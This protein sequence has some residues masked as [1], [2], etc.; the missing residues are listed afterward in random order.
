MGKVFLSP[1]KE[2]YIKKAMGLYRRYGS[3]YRRFKEMIDGRLNGEKQAFR[4]LRVVAD[5][6]PSIELLQKETEAEALDYLSTK[7]EDALRAI[8]RK[9]NRLDNNYGY[10]SMKEKEISYR[11][12]DSR[13]PS[14]PFKASRIRTFGV[15]PEHVLSGNAR[16]K[17]SYNHVD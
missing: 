4:I 2:D 17:R 1:R 16:K 3:S 11:W 12:I 15:D 6:F 7:K 9:V 14:C 10:R 5:E 13:H 8:I